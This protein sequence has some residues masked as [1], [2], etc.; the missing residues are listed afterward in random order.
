MPIS[1]LHKKIITDIITLTP[2]TNYA[3]S[4]YLIE[5]E[6][7]TKVVTLMGKKGKILI[8]LLLITIAPVLQLLNILLLKTTETVFILL[9]IM[10]MMIMAGQ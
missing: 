2:L 4:T 1:S 10:M 6:K 5:L 3:V 7:T 9:K 8:F